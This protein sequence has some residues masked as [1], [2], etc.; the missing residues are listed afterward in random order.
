MEVIFSF[1]ISEVLTIRDG[2]RRLMDD[3]NAH[4]IDRKCAE[5]LSNKINDIVIKAYQDM[6]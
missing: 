1:N 3:K 5:R 2:L 6:E 4:P